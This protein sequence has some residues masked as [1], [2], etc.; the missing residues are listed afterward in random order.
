VGFQWENN[1]MIVVDNLKARHGRTS[2][3]GKR[4]ILTF[5]TDDL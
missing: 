3:T 4:R 1:D 5:L 2:Y